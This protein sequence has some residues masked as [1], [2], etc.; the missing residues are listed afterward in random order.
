MPL[1]VDVS[2]LMTETLK[3]SSWVPASPAL[4]KGSLDSGGFKTW[5]PHASWPHSGWGWW[6]SAPGVSGLET[7]PPKVRSDPPF[8]V[9]LMLR[10]TA[11]KSTL[12]RGKFMVMCW[13]P[14]NRRRHQDP[15]IFSSLQRLAL[16]PVLQPLLCWPGNLSMNPPAQW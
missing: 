10:R 16:H 4:W 14:S 6:P 2:V 3:P 7:P 11:A 8:S 13:P 9:W 15:G 12:W 5:G 1:W